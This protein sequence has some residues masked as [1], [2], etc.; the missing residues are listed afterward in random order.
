MD[1]STPSGEHAWFVNRAAQLL[2]FADPWKGIN[3]MD[4]AA[5]E[6]DQAGDR[7][8]EGCA[9]ADRGMLRCFAATSGA[10]WPTSEKVSTSRS[11]LRTKEFESIATSP[12]G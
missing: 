11:V 6:A 5:V 8:L 10:V 9:I 2:R 7:V 4:Q 1:Q 12:F 3:Y